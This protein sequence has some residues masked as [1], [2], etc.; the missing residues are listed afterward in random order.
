MT[1]LLVRKLSNVDV[2]DCCAGADDGLFGLKVKLGDGANVA[3]QLV[4]QVA[5]QSIPHVHNSVFAVFSHHGAKRTPTDKNESL[6]AARNDGY[7]FLRR[8]C[9]EI[10][11]GW[12]VSQTM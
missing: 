7:V 11:V 12:K 5:G 10:V 1:P 3:G 4:A 2:L 9:A 8:R 6:R